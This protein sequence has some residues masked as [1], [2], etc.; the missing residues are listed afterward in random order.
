MLSLFNPSNNAT[1]DS[2]G[3]EDYTIEDDREGMLYWRNSYFVYLFVWTLI[4][5]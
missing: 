4:C 3:Y 1:E 5:V 2:K